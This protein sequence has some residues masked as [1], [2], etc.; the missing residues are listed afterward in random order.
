M[1]P[2]SLQSS[3]LSSQKT[4][5]DSGL[6]SDASFDASADLIPKIELNPTS[7]ITI[8]TGL[9]IE[10]PTLMFQNFGSLNN[11]VGN[12]IYIRG[13]HKVSN[14]FLASRIFL[15]NA[16][17]FY[18]IVI[19]YLCIKNN[20]TFTFCTRIGCYNTE[21]HRN[22]YFLTLFFTSCQLATF[23]N[24]NLPR[25]ATLCLTTKILL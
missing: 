24:P 15:I 13:V 22:N 11:K 16:T 21:F 10:S 3:P 18:H 6:G 7:L 12:S 20:L 8:K 19:C 25:M 23:R 14:Y 2:S 9:D 17:V 1:C 4:D 5:E